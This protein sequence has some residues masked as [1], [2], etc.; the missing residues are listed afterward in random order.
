MISN[1]K[2]IQETIDDRVF[3]K[4]VNIIRQTWLSDDKSAIAKYCL[5]KVI[6]LKKIE[7]KTSLSFQPE[8]KKAS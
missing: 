3:M 8:T 2:T 6:I 7:K 1:S 5:W 4:D